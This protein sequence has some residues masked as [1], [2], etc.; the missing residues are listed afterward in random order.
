M[1]GGGVC[2]LEDVLL[3]EHKGSYGNNILYTAAVHK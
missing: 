3:I 1:G 2:V